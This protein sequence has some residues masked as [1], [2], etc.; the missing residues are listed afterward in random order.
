M[1]GFYRFAAV[2]PKLRVADVEFNVEELLRCYRLA[3]QEHAD[4]VVFPELCV[5]GYTCGDLFLQER[6]S[7]RRSR[8]RSGLRMRRRAV[9]PLR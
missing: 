8:R 6:C 9:G 5:T 1:F 4:A 2:V 3:E 7:W